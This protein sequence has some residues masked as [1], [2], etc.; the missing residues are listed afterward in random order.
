MG[1]ASEALVEAARAGHDEAVSC[2]K[3]DVLARPNWLRWATPY[4]ILGDKYV[5]AGWTRERPKGVELLVSPD[6]TFAIGVAP[7][8]RWT[9]I[10][11]D[12]ITDEPR[13]VSTRIDRGPL[14]GQ[15]TVGNRGQI[16]F[17]TAVHPAFGPGLLPNIQIWL[18]LHYWHEDPIA[19]QDEVRLELSVPV[20]F[21]VSSRITGRGAVTR[22][23]PR[24]ILPSIQLVASANYEDDHDDGDEEIDVEVE[25]R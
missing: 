2:T 1:L 4:R 3:N 20:E 19:G 15:V 9:G 14:T 8:D 13:M 21:C 6:R 16:H 24:L 7:G 11:R 25:R 12:P 22:F 5:P 18:L 23:E 17:A 10:E